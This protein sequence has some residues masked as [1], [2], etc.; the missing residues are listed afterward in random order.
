MITEQRCHDRILRL[1]IKVRALFKK[2]IAL[3]DRPE[4]VILKKILELITGD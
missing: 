4:G 2:N 3:A 1:Q